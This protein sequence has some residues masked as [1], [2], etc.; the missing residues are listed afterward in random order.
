MKD[1]LQGANTL[2]KFPEGW[3]NVAFDLYPDS[4]IVC[5]QDGTAEPCDASPV[6]AMMQYNPGAPDFCTVCAS[7]E[8]PGY[9]HHCCADRSANPACTGCPVSGTARRWLG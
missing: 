7:W 3:D 8:V 5:D 2:E 4:T 9:C 6:R 1:L